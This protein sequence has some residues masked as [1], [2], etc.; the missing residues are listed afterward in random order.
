MDAQCR[1]DFYKVH[2]LLNIPEFKV[3]KWSA[4]D[5]AAFSEG[6]RTLGA[7]LEEG[8]ALFTDLQKTYTQ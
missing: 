2:T 7:P 6:S 1:P 4:E 8:E 5:V 3:L